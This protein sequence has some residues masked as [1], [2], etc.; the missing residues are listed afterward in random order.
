MHPPTP[1]QRGKGGKSIAH[2]CRVN[3]YNLC[4]FRLF[5]DTD[6]MSKDEDLGTGL[7]WALGSIRVVL[8]VGFLWL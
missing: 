8:L 6:R 2:V 1:L 7:V 3:V 5:R 4:P